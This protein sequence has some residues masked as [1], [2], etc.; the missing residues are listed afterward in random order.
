MLETALECDASSYGIRAVLNQK[1]ADEWH[2]V[3]FASR[4]LNSDE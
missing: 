4:T 3:Q 1:H 2:P